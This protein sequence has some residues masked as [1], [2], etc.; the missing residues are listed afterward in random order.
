MDEVTSKRLHDEPG[1]VIDEVR[2][3]GPKWLTRSGRR[4]VA[5]VP[6]DR[7]EHHEHQREVAL[8]YLRRL[9]F[10]VTGEMPSSQLTT[11][12]V[13]E[14]G[15]SLLDTVAAVVDRSAAATTREPA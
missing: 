12:Q 5:L 13:V 6:H 11:E 2:T 14:L 1:A 10:V 3:G 8:D 15:E 7:Y 4:V 9:A